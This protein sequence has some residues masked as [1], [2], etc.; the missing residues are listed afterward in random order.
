MRSG[1]DLV[2][3][4]SRKF[5]GSRFSEFSGSIVFASE[6]GWSN[7]IQNLPGLG[8]SMASRSVSFRAYMRQAWD[9]N[10]ERKLL[11]DGIPWNSHARITKLMD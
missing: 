1:N 8:V 7:R 5:S 11:V 3:L 10:R 4:A 2:T 9:R 6:L